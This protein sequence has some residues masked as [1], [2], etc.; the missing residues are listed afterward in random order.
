MAIMGWSYGGYQTLYTMST[1]GHPFVAGIA[2]APVT[3]WRLYDSAYTE[4]YMRR[5]QVNASGYE[6]SSLMNRGAD[7]SGNVLIIH[8]TGDDNVHV[9]HTM[10]YIHALVEADKQFEMQ[11]YP[12]DNH[13]LR[14]GNNALHMHKR[15]KRFLDENL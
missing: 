13:H 8:G 11:L 3:D 9:Q 12:D 5:P 7:L 4:R 2:I 10:Q 1:K 15:I 14:K 6:E